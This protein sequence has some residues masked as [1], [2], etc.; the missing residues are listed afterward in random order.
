MGYLALAVAD[1]I[2]SLHVLW[3]LSFLNV[4]THEYFKT[5]E[6]EDVGFKGL[7]G[8]LVPFL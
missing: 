1:L 2:Y 4:P 3:S 5:F 8:G 6:I 7:D